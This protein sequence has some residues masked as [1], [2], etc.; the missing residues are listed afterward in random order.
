[1]IT[2]AR[3]KRKCVEMSRFVQRTNAHNTSHTIAGIHRTHLSQ[4]DLGDVIK[5]TRALGCRQNVKKNAPKNDILMGLPPDRH[6]IYLI[7]SCHPTPSSRP[8]AKIKK[9]KPTRKWIILITLAQTN[10]NPWSLMVG[11][12]CGFR[13]C[14]IRALMLRHLDSIHFITSR[15]PICFGTRWTKNAWIIYNTNAFETSNLTCVKHNII[16]TWNGA[17]RKPNQRKTNKR[18]QTQHTKR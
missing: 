16:E 11:W 4:T 17:R 9:I 1:M 6:L 14:Q 2:D 13:L 7:C 12:F 8:G 10:A 15:I 18:I 3:G 5:T